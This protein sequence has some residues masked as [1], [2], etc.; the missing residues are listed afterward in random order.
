MEKMIDTKHPL[1]SIIVP[2][3]NVENYLPR[4]LEDIL[5][6]TYTNLE[7]ILVNDGSRD[8]SA[9]ICDDFAKK[10]ARI[11]V[12]HQ[13]NAGVS[14]ARNTGLDHANGTYI[15]FIDSDDRVHNRFI[16][17]LHYYIGSNKLITCGYELFDQD[18]EVNPNNQIDVSQNDIKQITDPLKKLVDIFDILYVVPW[19]KL[20]V[21]SLFDQIRYP[22][23]RVH[24]DEFVI[25]EILHQVDVSCY[26]D[27]P[28]YYYRR[29][30]GSIT[31]DETN[32]AGF[33]DKTEAIYNR[34]NF[35]LDLSRNDDASTL[36]SALLKRFVL[37]TIKNTN[38]IWSQYG[39]RDIYTNDTLGFSTRLILLI[40]KKCYPLYVAMVKIGRKLSK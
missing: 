3:Y 20:Y 10:D 4:C 18:F 8:S 35:F 33:I 27:I 2:I 6:Q 21:K 11:T 36:D 24:E 23:G 37:P 22:C 38:H 7:V 26:M 5:A 15:S 14:A 39:L 32:V 34:R 1:V 31:A 25:H 16:E 28:L 40:K 19:N 13:E 29:R 9:S 12:I 17:L 30:A